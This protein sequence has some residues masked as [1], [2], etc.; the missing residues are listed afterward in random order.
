MWH[1]CRC[2]YL[3]GGEG[4]YEDN[5]VCAGVWWCQHHSLTLLWFSDL[6]QM[7]EAVAAA[8]TSPCL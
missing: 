2:V 5:M 7:I 6:K 1:C 3:E 8:A 4:G